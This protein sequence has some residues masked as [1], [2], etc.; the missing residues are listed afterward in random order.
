[1]ESLIRYL[2]GVENGNIVDPEC[3]FIVKISV[4]AISD[5]ELKEEIKSYR[6]WC[7]Q[8]KIVNVIAYNFVS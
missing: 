8:A 1:M 7:I 3:V 4:D 6:E 2:E 5:F